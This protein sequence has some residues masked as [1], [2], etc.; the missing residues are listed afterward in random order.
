MITLISPV[1]SLVTRHEDEHSDDTLHVVRGLNHD[2]LG[3]NS[4]NWYSLIVSD[5][6]SST[7]HLMSFLFAYFL[8]LDQ[9]DGKFLC[10]NHM[11]PFE[12]IFR[13]AAF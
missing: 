11:V 9:R 8:A 13:T 5:A 2:P 6:I 12:N 3:S 1:I 10:L 4:W 7:C